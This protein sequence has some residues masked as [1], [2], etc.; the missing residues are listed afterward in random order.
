MVAAGISKLVHEE[1]LKWT[2][3]IKEIIPEFKTQ[4]ASIASMTTVIDLLAQRTGLSG[5]ISFTFQGD[6]DALMTADQLLLMVQHMESVTPFREQCSYSSWGY[7]LAGLVIERLSGQSLRQFL[8]ASI[9]DPL[10]MHSTTTQPHIQ[11]GDNVAEPHA[12]LEDSTPYHLGKRMVLKDTLFKAAAGAYTNVDDM[13]RWCSALL[14]ISDPSSKPNQESKSPLKGLRMVLSGHVPLM[15]P[16]S[17]E[18]SYAMGWVRTQLPG[19]LGVLGENMDILGAV[20]ELPELGRGLPSK[21]CIYHLG[22]TVGY[23]SPVFL[24]PE[25]QSA[26]VVLTNSIPLTDAPDNLGQAVAQALFGFHDPIDFV[27]LTKMVKG[28]LLDQH[29]DMASEISRKKGPDA[30]N[31]A[32]DEYIGKYVNE[33]GNFVLTIEK[34]DVDGSVLQLSFQGL[35]SQSYELRPLDGDTFEWSM[36]LDEEARRGRY[37][38]TSTSYF[39]IEFL[40][41]K[42]KI[43]RLRWAESY[44][45]AKQDESPGSV[46]QSKSEL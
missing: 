24:F 3:P 26:I 18:R 15:S 17:R 2:T 43:T 42:G 8:K 40:S 10:G 11:E 7:S 12:T 38:I 27:E 6:G 32:L 37:H 46:P 19:V 14:S 9:F 39:V 31:R 45:F 5:D 4:H 34:H 35:K 16:S 36:T 13:L 22:A 20:S 28:R 29:K 30:P 23:Y 21:L 25:S 41:D 44:M 33:L 1:K